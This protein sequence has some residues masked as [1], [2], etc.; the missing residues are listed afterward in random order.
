ML[1]GPVLQAANHPTL[2]TD[3]LDLKRRLASV[4]FFDQLTLA[5]QRPEDTVTI[6]AVIESLQRKDFVI[7]SETD[8]DELHA[9]MM[10]LNTAL[11]DASKQQHV[12]TPEESQQFDALVDELAEGMRNMLTRVAPQNKGIHVSRIE[13]KSA[14]EMIRERLLYQVRTKKKPKIQGIRLDDHNEAE[15]MLKQQEFMNDFFNKDRTRFKNDD[16][17][18]PSIEAM[19]T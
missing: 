15:A 14:M 9:L 18:M 12:T 19:M 13:A 6:T 10:L 8:Y 5:E 7:N 4:F 11:G 16:K 1:L 2:K 17:P 3:T